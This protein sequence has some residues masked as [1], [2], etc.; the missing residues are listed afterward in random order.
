MDLSVNLRSDVLK[1]SEMRIG[2]IL[3]VAVGAL[4]IMVGLGVK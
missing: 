2:K 3:L 4:T 1:R